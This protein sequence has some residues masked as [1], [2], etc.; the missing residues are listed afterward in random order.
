MSKTLKMFWNKTEEDAKE[1][2]ENLLTLDI[3]IAKVNIF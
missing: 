1:I 3:E 2:S